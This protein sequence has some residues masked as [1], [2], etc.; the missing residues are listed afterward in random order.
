VGLG[1]CPAGESQTGRKLKA[2]GDS[3]FLA[4]YALYGLLQEKVFSKTK[5]GD[6][7]ILDVSYVDVG[8]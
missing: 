3:S 2:L 7:W 6:L 1:D 8:M 4:Q 5:M